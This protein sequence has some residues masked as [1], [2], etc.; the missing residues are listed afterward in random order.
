MP[1]YTALLNEAFQYAYIELDSDL[2]DLGCVDE[3]FI[4]RSVSC[5]APPQKRERLLQDFSRILHPDTN[6]IHTAYLFAPAYRD[7]TFHFVVLTWVKDSSTPI[8]FQ[9]WQFPPELPNLSKRERQTMWLLGKGCCIREIA[10]KLSVAES[11]IRSNLER[12]KRK[13]DVSTMTDLLFV[14]RD[15][16]EAI[17]QAKLP[18]A[19][20]VQPKDT[21]FLQRPFPA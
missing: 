18:A 17:K 10:E 2:R 11:T 13:L 3:D 20:I 5:F 21:H 9:A 7:M 15:Y 4:G 14:A 16:R 8:L 12:I 19:S 1:R 6:R